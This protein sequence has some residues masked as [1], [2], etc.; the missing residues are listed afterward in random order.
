MYYV[1]RVIIA[2]AVELV[3]GDLL[4]MRDADGIVHVVNC[5]CTKGHGLS[6]DIAKK[7]SW[8]ISILKENQSNTGI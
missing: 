8:G 5:L 2:M 3:R 1:H 6:L 4:E 7:F